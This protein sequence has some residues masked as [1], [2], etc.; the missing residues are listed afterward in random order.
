MSFSCS[1][2]HGNDDDHK[3]LRTKV[4]KEMEE[5][6]EFFADQFIQ[7]AQEA[8]DPLFVQTLLSQAFSDVA[9]R[10]FSSCLEGE[11]SVRDALISSVKLESTLGARNGVFAGMLE[12]AALASVLG[13]V[14]PTRFTCTRKP[15][16]NR[17][18]CPRVRM[19]CDEEYV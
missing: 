3:L 2:S 15:Y 6:P 18:F 9:S 19:Q 1:Q 16:I 14:F 8:A 5:N 4:M 12:L 10:T 7:R 17:T 13:S 11:L